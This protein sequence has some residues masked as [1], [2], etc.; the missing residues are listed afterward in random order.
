MER[1][2][3]MVHSFEIQT[4]AE[5]FSAMEDQFRDYLADGLSSRKAV[6]S[7]MLCWHIADWVYAESAALQSK[8]PKLVDFH[9]HITSQCPSLQV[10]QDVTNGTKHRDLRTRRAGIVRTEPR[11]G[12]FSP[13]FSRDFDRAELTIHLDDGSSTAFDIEFRKA[14]NYWRQFFAAELGRTV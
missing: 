7:A 8:F 1:S 3:K 12:A 14:L 10:M 13:E 9:R 5:L 4:A 11:H 2:R 6:M